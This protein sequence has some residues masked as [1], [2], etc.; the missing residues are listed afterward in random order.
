MANNLHQ[1]LVEESADMATIIDA[2]GQI[3]YVS[4]SIQ[5]TLGY[6]PEEIVGDVGYEHQHPDD[7]ETVATAIEHIEAN[8]DDTQVIETRFRHADGSW[9]WVE[10]TLQNRF[11]DETIDGILVNSRDIT[12]QKRRAR[13]HQ[14]LASE[15]TTL[16]STVEDGIFFLSVESTDGG[17]EFRFER[18]NEAYEEQTGLTTEDMKGKTPTEVFGEEVGAELDANYRRCAR[19]RKP[20]TYEEEVPVE[21]D[22]RFWQTNLAPV[23]TDGEVTRIIGITRN[24]T[25]RVRQER[26]LQRKNDQL[27]EFA[28][29]ISHDLRNPLN[30][31]QARSTLLAEECESDHL[32]PIVRSLDRME[33]LISDTLTLARQGQ[34]VA[35]PESIPLV[36]L[37]GSC[38]KNVSTEAATIDIADNIAIKGDRSRLQHVFENLFRNAVEH[39]GKDVTVTVGTTDGHCLYV[40]DTG[41]G[42]P[43]A[44]RQEV[45]EPGA[46]SADN[47]T[48]FGLTIV[49]RIAEAHGWDVA[50]VE[51]SAGGTR[52]EFT[53]VDIESR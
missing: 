38:W 53:G 39:G 36:D 13:E 22:A 27:E 44:E 24:I 11:D 6:D 9:R 52:F 1:K 12:D 51:G 3:A 43:E 37:V 4:P 40:E 25:E 35:D 8:P 18:L 30:V 32:D 42:I 14:Q 5:D 28:S 19:D 34:V 41:P 16:L 20:I 31:A 50:I 10:A 7:R 21:T 47:G 33:E 49:R 23:V 2:D 15:Y 46:T 48:G 29:V 26:Q 17:Y 45:F